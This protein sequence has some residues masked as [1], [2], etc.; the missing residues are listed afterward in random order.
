M[1]G[2]QATGKIHSL[3]TF[4]KYTGSVTF[5]GERGRGHAGVRHLRDPTPERGQVYLEERA[6][7]V[8][9]RSS[10]MPTVMRCSSLPVGTPSR[11]CTHAPRPSETPAQVQAI[12]ARQSERNTLGTEFAHRSRRVD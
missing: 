10:S 11:G 1:K 2:S 4:E 9:A 8:W 3:R 5:A 7:K 12:T 6:L